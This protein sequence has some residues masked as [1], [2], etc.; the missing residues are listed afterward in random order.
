MWPRKTKSIPPVKAVMTPF[1]HSIEASEPLAVAAEMMT[2]FGFHH[3][4]VMERG[5]LVGLI[6]EPELRRA[7]RTGG[8][9]SA[10]LVADVTRHD[11]LVVDLT[12]PL[13]RVL[14]KMAKDRIGSVLV[15]K[16][17][18]L[19]GIFTVTDA[20]RSYAEFLQTQF[21]PP[22]GDEAA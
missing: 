22:G 4:P 9:S 3:L 15:V 20:C 10:L 6:S 17:G 12:E 8:R 21:P 2:R 5:R 11:V 18:R 14:S 16:D 19:A 1:P 7:E 13:D